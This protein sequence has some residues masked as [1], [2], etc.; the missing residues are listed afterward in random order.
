MSWMRRRI[1][2]AIFAFAAVFAAGEVHAQMKQIP[3]LVAPAITRAP[4]IIL[5]PP[6][7]ALQQ[8][9]KIQPGGKALNV[10][11]VGKNFQVRLKVGSEIREVLVEGTTGE[12][13]E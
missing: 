11:R 8:A 13:I 5:I 1:F 7:F 9:L 2:I 10:R 12:V 4:R 3:R 6:S